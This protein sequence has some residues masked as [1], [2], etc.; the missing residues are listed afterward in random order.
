MKKV[1]MKDM[2]NPYFW[3]NYFGCS[4]PNA[5]DE[6]ED[7]SVSDLMQEILT[8]ESGRWWEQLTGYY[9]GILE[10]NDGYLDEPA[11]LEVMLTRDKCMKIE[12]HPGD[13]LYYINGEKIGSTGPHWEVQTIPYEEV[14]QLLALEDGCRLY[15][16]L[17]PLAVIKPEEA[18]S[19]RREIG[20]QMGKYFPES[21]CR[22]VSGCIA[23][24]L[25]R[26]QTN[27]EREEN[28]DENDRSV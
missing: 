22:S 21:L 16:L 2:D 4:Y 24:G 10:E 11:S 1:S 19:V 7:V 25:V 8:E 13:I 3:V 9:D 5:Y 15:L 18:D 12:F 23:A 20:E 28:N 17:L 27:C 26:G 14:R 6:E